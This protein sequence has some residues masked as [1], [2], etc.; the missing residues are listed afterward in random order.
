MNSEFGISLTEVIAFGDN[1][2]DIEMLQAAGLGIAVGNAK[3]EVKMV[4]NEI[5][6]NSVDDGVA[7][8]IE[9]YFLP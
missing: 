3:E 6:M 7:V 5:T 4:A 2:N 8:A 9:K 1:Y